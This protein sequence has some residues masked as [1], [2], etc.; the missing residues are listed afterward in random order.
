MN[1]NKRLKAIGFDSIEAFV[2]NC[3]KRSKIRT[4]FSKKEVSFKKEELVLMII[5]AGSPKTWGRPQDIEQK[6]KQ[7]YELHK[8]VKDLVTRYRFINEQLQKAKTFKDL[9]Q[10]AMM[11]IANA[12]PNLAMVSG[13]ISTGGKG[14]IRLNILAMQEYIEELHQS[15]ENMFDQTIFE[16]PMERIKDTTAG[17]D[18]R[19]LNQFY[20]SIFESKHIKKMFFMQDWESSTGANWEHEQM[21]RLDIKRIYQ[22]I[23][24]QA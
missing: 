6:T 24:I 1:I 10:I 13:P 7:V 4:I 18:H 20:L 19:I 15:G 8:G 2:K 22:T 23:Q 9:L 17:Y 11:I 3:E 12:H 16:E 5:L 14:S 21:I